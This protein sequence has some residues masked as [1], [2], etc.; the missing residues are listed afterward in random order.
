MKDKPFATLKEEIQELEVTL[1]ET[2]NSIIQYEQNH[3][4]EEQYKD[5]KFILKIKFNTEEKKKQINKNINYINKSINYLEKNIKKYEKLFENY[6]IKLLEEQK[7][8]NLKIKKIS[9]KNLDIKNKKFKSIQEENKKIINSLK[10]ELSK[11]LDLNTSDVQVVIQDRRFKKIYEKT[12]E[13][14]DS[15]IK[16]KL[17]NYYK[18]ENLQFLI[19]DNEFELILNKMYS[20]EKYKKF[21]KHK[22]EDSFES[23]SSREC[24]NIHYYSEKV[25]NTPESILKHKLNNQSV[26]FCNLDKGLHLGIEKEKK[27]FLTENVDVFKLQQI[28]KSK[29]HTAV[30]KNKINQ[31]IKNLHKEVTDE[32]ERINN[33]KNFGTYITDDE[34]RQNQINSNFVVFGKTMD[35]SQRLKYFEKIENLIQEDKT[36]L[37]NNHKSLKF[38]EDSIVQLFKDIDEKEKNRI[39]IGI[40][41]TD[42]EIKERNQIKKNKQIYVETKKILAQKK[43]ELRKKEL[44][45]YTEK[46]KNIK[47]DEDVKELNDRRFNL[48]DKNSS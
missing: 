12:K 13:N 27:N 1:T 25:F 29:K 8:K 6:Q 39:E 21:W 43:E 10:D 37:K 42:K 7:S 23:C 22:L 4:K 28:L 9:K 15:E 31:N 26:F 11:Y 38:E 2:N 14:V 36:E 35:N 5:K 47:V 18:F 41:E 19:T 40:Y 17:N 30:N 44:A 46:S 34:L 32:K 45:F 16:E 48:Y 20:S 33:Y 3:P 24:E